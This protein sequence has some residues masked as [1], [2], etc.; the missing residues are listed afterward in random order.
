[1][2]P[3]ILAST[4]VPRKLLLERLQIP[5][6]CA[7]PD[8]DETSL[9]DEKPDE[10]VLRLAKQKAEA[11]APKFSNALIIGADQVGVLDNTIICKPLIHEQ[12]IKQLLMMSG[13]RI[14]FLIGLCLLDTK[15][16]TQQLALETYDVTFRTLS[17]STIQNYLKKE[18]VLNCAG[19]F[20]IEGLGISLVAKLEG[21]DYTA[22][23]GLP[24]IRLVSMLNKADFNVV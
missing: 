11:V 2:Q 21:H 5:F 4:S 9:P 10:L 19:S 20:S 14:K 24:L 15:N 13:K 3:L 7:A 16:N 23:I 17:L 22:L 6:T 18:A 12:A 1:M 8:V